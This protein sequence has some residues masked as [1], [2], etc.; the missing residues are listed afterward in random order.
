MGGVASSAH[1]GPFV[2]VKNKAPLIL[3][4]GRKTMVFLSVNNTLVCD[5]FHFTFYYFVNDLNFVAQIFILFP[6]TNVL[7]ITSIRASFSDAKKHY[8]YV[9]QNNVYEF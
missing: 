4:F 5:A 6:P 3:S 8:C 9:H 1:I 2:F 7:G